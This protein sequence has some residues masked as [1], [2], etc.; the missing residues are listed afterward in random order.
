MAFL[1]DF[2]LFPAFVS[3][4]PRFTIVHVVVRIRSLESYVPPPS[5]NIYIFHCLRAQ[6]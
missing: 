3:S 5:F 2:G 6:T 4:L 1:Q